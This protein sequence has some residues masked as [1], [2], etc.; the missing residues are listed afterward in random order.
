MISRINQD[1]W[2]RKNQIS[3][4]LNGELVWKSQER[5]QIPINESL[6]GSAGEG[7]RKAVVC[8]VQ[9]NISELSFILNGIAMDFEVSQAHV[10]EL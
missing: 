8:D 2:I 3:G 9:L 4:Q 1:N 7:W 6:R 10:G 5:A